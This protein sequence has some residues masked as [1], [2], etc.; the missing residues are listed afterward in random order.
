MKSVDW[1]DLPS[2]A[3]EIVD[4]V[5]RTGKSIVITKNG[6]PALRIDPVDEATMAEFYAAT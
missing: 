2:I 6:L 5:Q 3:I 1:F 4:E